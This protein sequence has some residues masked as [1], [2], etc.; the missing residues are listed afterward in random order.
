[1]FYAPKKQISSFGMP[2]IVTQAYTSLRLLILLPRLTKVRPR[3]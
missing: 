1:M 2:L 3:K